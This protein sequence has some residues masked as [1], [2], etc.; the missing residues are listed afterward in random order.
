MK[1]AAIQARQADLVQQYAVAEA[2]VAA[3]KRAAAIKQGLH[4][5]VEM[6]SQKGPSEIEGIITMAM[7]DNAPAEKLASIQ[8]WTESLKAAASAR[9]AS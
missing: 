4:D 1:L 5:F 7:V 2:V 9:D 6:L 3:E 8:Q